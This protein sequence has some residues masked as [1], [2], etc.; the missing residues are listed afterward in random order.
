[1]W[2]TLAL[3]LLGPVAALALSA[4]TDTPVDNLTR[5]PAQTLAVA[6]YLG[7]LSMVG[8]ALWSATVAVCLLGSR[9]LH[10]EQS[11]FLLAAGMLS[12]LLL[13]DDALVLH[14]GVIPR[15]LHIPEPVILG[16]YVLL[17]AA[18]FVRFFRHILST[19][20][21]LLVIAL[22]A[23]TA[24]FG[25]DFAGASQEH[26]SGSI[27]FVEDSFKFMGIAF[28]MSYFVHVTAAAL[29]RS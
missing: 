21:S 17:A 9:L 13:F 19:N 23:F 18:F 26:A 6:S 20:Y 10:G 11:Y 25:I 15:I 29:R 14:E 27:I 3:G 12:L 16:A 7:L 8:L 5:D 4:V 2:V 22:A 1:M 28:W 24:S